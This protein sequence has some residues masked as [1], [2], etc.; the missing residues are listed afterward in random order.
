MYTP[1]HFINRDDVD[2]CSLIK[3]SP[4][5]TLIALSTDGFEVNHIPFVIDIENDVAVRLR[6]H[7]PKANPMFDILTKSPVD[8][9]VIFQG[10]ES[11]VSPSWYATKKEHGKVVPTWNYKVVHVHGEL[12]LKQDQ[13]W[14][15][16]QLNDLTNQ[17]EA[18]RSKKWSV[19][20]APESYLQKQLSVLVGLEVNISRLDSK[21]KA[22]Q[23]QP[24]RNRESV[25]NALQ[26]EQPDSGFHKMMKEVLDDAS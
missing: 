17:N 5:G 3:T 22:S 15:V 8:C 6:A 26:V 9:V 19:S 21:V 13:A 2:S 25:L 11:Y 20:D 18:S 16:Q 23:N 14:I 7:I 4:L 24:A 1:S 10:P 12:N